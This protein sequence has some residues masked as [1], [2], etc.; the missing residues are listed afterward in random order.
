MGFFVWCEGSSLWYAGFSLVVGHGLQNTW[1]QQLPRVSSVVLASGLS[2]LLTRD[3]TCIPCVGRWTL[4]HWTPREVL[5]LES[6]EDVH[7]SRVGNSQEVAISIA[8]GPGWVH[9]LYEPHFLY[10]YYYY[11]KGIYCFGASLMAQMA[12]N[13][14]AM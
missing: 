11:Y 6:L 8:R 3:R 7:F 1:A 13:L 10:H 4:N 5:I 14:P 9:L 2:C 12:K